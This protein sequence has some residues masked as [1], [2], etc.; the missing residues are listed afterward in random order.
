MKAFTLST[1]TTELPEGYECFLVLDDN[2]HPDSTTWNNPWYLAIVGKYGEIIEQSTQGHPSM[3]MALFGKYFES[4]I[5]YGMV[6]TLAECKWWKN[7]SLSSEAS[8]QFDKTVV[9]D[10]KAQAKPNTITTDI[11]KMVTGP[12]D[13][14]M[15]AYSNSEE[16]F[17]KQADRKVAQSQA[18]INSKRIYKL[19]Q[20]VAERKG[21]AKQIAKMQKMLDEFDKINKE[22][23]QARELQK[24][25]KKLR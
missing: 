6:G 25:L 24:L 15:K 4:G 7:L 5:L 22:L 23:D 18:A 17:V 9:D 10:L 19:E 20:A 16:V 1:Q 12:I 2:L 11:P 3:H 8:K 13:D 14:F 21:L